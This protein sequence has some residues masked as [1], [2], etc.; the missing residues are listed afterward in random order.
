VTAPSPPDLVDS[1][2][3]AFRLAVT[4]AIMT[5]GAS[6]M[7]VVPVVLPAVQAEFGVA[8]ADASLPYSLLMAGMGVGG[9]LMGRL[10]DRFG[11]RVPLL[12]GAAGI[13]AGYVAA[14]FAADIHAFNLLHGLVLGLLGVASTFSPLM[15]DTSLWWAKALRRR[16]RP[17]TAPPATGPSAC[18]PRPR[19]RC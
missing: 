1:P 2:Y 15:A 10:A 8:R 4:L 18:R 7:Y 11:V 19:R 9:I 16:P 14:G 6:A 12:V 3:A 17:R 5:I 13:G